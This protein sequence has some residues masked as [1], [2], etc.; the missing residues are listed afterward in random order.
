MN[1]RMQISFDTDSDGFLSQ[2]CPAC[3]K[4]FKANF[5]EGSDQP[6]SFCPY[7][8]HQ[9]RDC[10]WTQAQAD[11]I[12]NAVS[13]ELIDPTMEKMARDFNRKIPKDGLISMKMKYKPG[14]RSVAPKEPNEDWPKLLFECCGETIKHDRSMDTLHCVI[15]GRTKPVK[16]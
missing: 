6:L 10:W 11:Y 15:C 13:N 16:E 12:I 9:G 1:D 3:H 7:C 8:A 5:S 4:R 14:P 2:E